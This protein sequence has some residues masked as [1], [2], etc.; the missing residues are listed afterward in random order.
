MT[1]IE[2]EKEVDAIFS[3]CKN[4]LIN[5]GRE[6]QSTEEEGVD[7][8]ANFARGAADVAINRESILWIYFSKHRDS[9]STFIKDLQKGKSIK[10]IEKNLTEPI[11]GRIIDA[12]N[13]LLLLNSMIN[14]KRKTEI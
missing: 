5:K 4:T 10:E 12:I 1:T 9:L 13:Y 2:F 11:N 8:F 6:Y 3:E 14:D 7:V